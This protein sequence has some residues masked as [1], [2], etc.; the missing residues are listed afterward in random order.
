MNAQ[1]YVQ[2]KNLTMLFG[3]VFN[4]YEGFK[5]FIKNRIKQKIKVRLIRLIFIKNSV[6]Q[7]AITSKINF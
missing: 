3:I 6:I 5:Q 7:I 4:N 1:K 2:I